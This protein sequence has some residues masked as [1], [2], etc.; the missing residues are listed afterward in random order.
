M[1]SVTVDKYTIQVHQGELPQSHRDYKSKAKLYDQIEPCDEGDHS[2]IA[3]AEHGAWPHLCAVLRYRDASWL[4]SPGVLLVPETGIVFI[5]GGDHALAYDLH[6]PRRLWNEHAAYFWGWQRHG[7]VV[8]MSA[9]LEFT[10]WTI[11]GEKLW[12]TFVEPW[13]EYKV[14]NGVVL[15]DVMDVRST[16]PLH[17]GPGRWVH[18]N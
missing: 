15:L 12:T 5:G 16:F 3:V 1:I 4:F 7:E 2:F 10:A 17:E 13:W 11:S 6:A 14:E 9:E 18:G 8:L